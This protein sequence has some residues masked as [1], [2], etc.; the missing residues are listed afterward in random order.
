MSCMCGPPGAQR[1]AAEGVQGE[2]AEVAMPCN[3]VLLHRESL[4][5]GRLYAYLNA[6]MTQWAIGQRYG[7]SRKSV[8]K[9]I[10]KWHE[11]FDRIPPDPSAVF[12]SQ[13]P[14][15]A[16]SMLKIRDPYS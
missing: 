13:E 3:E 6:D 1:G 11:A 15:R 4:R 9:L 7:V 8:S 16:Q 5:R 14:L 2:A 12:V 10:A